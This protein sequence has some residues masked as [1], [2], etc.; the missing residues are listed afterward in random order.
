M[1][2]PSD[3]TVLA[4]LRRLAA[5]SLAIAPGELQD[6]RSL[7][8][9]GL[10]SLSAIELQGAIAASLGVEL[11]LD[12]LLPGPSLAELERLTLGSPAR[13]PVAAPPPAALAARAPL[14]HGQRALWLLDRMAPGSPAG[15]IAG[16]ARLSGELDV[17]RLRRALE[18]LVARH[19]SLRS[20][21]ELDGGEPVQVVHEAVHEPATLAF[22]EGDAGAWDEER[23]GEHLAAAAYEPFDLARGPLL[24]AALFHRTAAEHLLVLAVHHVVADFWSLGVLVGELRA[25]WQGHALPPLPIAYGDFVRRE[26]ERLAGPEAERLWSYWNAALAAPP[27]PLD[28][29]SD[30]PR[31]P[32]PSYRGAARSLGLDHDLSQRLPALGRRVGA[33]PFMTLL[34]AYLVL[35]HRH[36]GQQDLLVGTPTAGRNSPALAGLVGY[37]VNPVVVRGDLGGD[38]AFGELLG[39]VREA[40]IGALA[41]QDLPFPLLAER[42]ATPRDP[43]RPPLFQVMFVLYRERQEDARGLGG[44]AVGARGATL[45]LGGNLRLESLPLPRRSS[46]LDLTLMAAESGG[47]LACSLL[48]NSDLFDAATAERMLGHHFH[49]LL[50][51][52]VAGAERPVSQLPLLALAERHQL[53][54]EWNAT[55]W[56]AAGDDLMHAPFERQAARDPAAAALI[57]GLR[58]GRTLSYGELDRRANR[59]ARALRAA[60]VGPEGRV[61]ICAEPSFAMVAG[62]LAVLKAGG[63]YLPLDPALPGERLAQ[64]LADSGARVALVEERLAGLLPATVRCL[65]LDGAGARPG[66]AP[67]A[68]GAPLPHP[69]NAAYV[70]YTSGSTGV[71]KGVVV[72]HRAVVNRLRFQVAADLAPGA[73]V[74]QRTR[75]GFDVSVLEIFAP[76]WM[77]GSV[78]LAASGHQ[79]DAAHLARLV[80][81][82]QVTNAT[83]PPAMYPALLADEAFCRSPS[84][85]LLVTGS[86]RVPGDLP[87]RLLAAFA[88]RETAPPRFTARYG[89]TETTIAVAEWDCRR[90]AA[91]QSVPLG[92]PIAGARF[93]LLDR[94]QRE[95]PPGVPGEL[96]V[97]G[98]CLARGYLAWPALT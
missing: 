56:E 39:R 51:E 62:L 8:A 83:F 61:G 59:L 84:L 65:P 36:S 87:R 28:L 94:H 90:E 91:G 73:R 18:A 10:D 35:L 55:A 95:V 67:D 78:V 42:L 12:D 16:A 7:I 23:L 71:P 29:P 46:Q 5:R 80:V 13:P 3:P 44:F 49:T 33:T 40:V 86:D 53:R 97:A 22:V 89:P 72:S 96:C 1:T 9:H 47:R 69:A 15:I 93:H 14:S 31:P 52:I 41:H 85:R 48:F 77:G 75:L 68:G 57:D 43:S 60:G 37:F 98:I 66:P 38:P 17:P 26:A 81:E 76:L 92:R 11:A 20:T 54:C 45:D 4:E 2:R 74:L 24:R 82:Q 50:R 27:P 6:D 32:L 79:Q 63:A 19:S 64:I 88:R 25:L 21:F 70:M 30:R 34:A 58:V